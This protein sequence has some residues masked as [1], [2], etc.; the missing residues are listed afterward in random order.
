VRKRSRGDALAVAKA[1]HAPAHGTNFIKQV[2]LGSARDVAKDVLWCLKNGR[3][4]GIPRAA[5][6][7]LFHRYGSWEGFNCGQF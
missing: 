2:A 3:I 6:T 1:G 4:A 5:L 7:R